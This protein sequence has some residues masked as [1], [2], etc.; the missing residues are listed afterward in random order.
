M[1]VINNLYSRRIRL[2]LSVSTTFEPLSTRHQSRGPSSSEDSKMTRDGAL[3][4]T[5]CGTC[6]FLLEKG[7]L[8]GVT[9]SWFPCIC[10]EVIKEEK[11]LHRGGW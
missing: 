3:A 6:L 8:W 11:T 9:K 2:F 10:R 4:R 1:E 5:W 7:W